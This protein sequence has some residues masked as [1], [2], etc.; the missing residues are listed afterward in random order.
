MARGS[1]R[2]LPSA[3]GLAGDRPEP[4]P[5]A[6]PKPE[7]LAH[8]GHGNACRRGVGQKPTSRVMVLPFGACPTGLKSKTLLKKPNLLTVTWNPAL[9]RSWVA[10]WTD[11]PIGSGTATSCGPVDTCTITV[12]PGWMRP[13]AV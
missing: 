13:P 12:S 1:V 4:G 5:V 3:Q 8:V 11:M 2:S 6:K 7:L 9:S 10:S